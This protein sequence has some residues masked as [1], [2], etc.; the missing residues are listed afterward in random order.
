M[1]IVNEVVDG[2]TWTWTVNPHMPGVKD[3]HPDQQ[4][5]FEETT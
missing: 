2:N 5:L 4:S 1:L 3:E